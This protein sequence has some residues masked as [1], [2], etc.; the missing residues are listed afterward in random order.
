MVNRTALPTAL[1][2]SEAARALVREA[3]GVDLVV[4]SALFRDSF[5]TGGRGHVD[6][7]RLRSVG[8]KV[9][10]LTV[11]TAWP[12]LEG[13]LSRWHFRSLG[14]PASAVGSN[15]AIAD[16]LIGRIDGW[17]ARSDGRLRIIRTR[18]DL[19]ACF[20][21]DGPTGVLI[22][23]QGA[24]VLDGD[25]RNVERLRARGVRMLAPAH[26]MDNAAVGSGTGRF[27]GG[28][29]GHGRDVLAALEEASIVVDLAHMSVRGI[30]EALS[31]VQRPFVVS[32]TGL[33]D[34]AGARSRLRRFSPATRNIPA[35]LAAQV[36]AAGG[37]IG[38]VLSTELLAASSLP[39][40]TRTFNAA[41]EAAGPAHVSLGSDMD[42]ALKMLIDV[43][44]IP[45]LADALLSAGMDSSV[46]AGI[47]G[48]NAVSLLQAALTTTG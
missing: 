9:V 26:V 3:P 24:H 37:L 19:A 6:L 43:E 36:G 47:L 35:S 32:H 45:A 13:R 34:V 28:L 23:V 38:I 27:A 7:P 29:T 22:G 16:W 31:V 41:V 30:E 5:L 44:G 48:G 12:E 18:D 33:T 21:P 39:D 42:G 10:G 2:A 15:M 20:A 40:A 8:I 4:G 46:V 1:P 25:V 14:M 11:A 17:V